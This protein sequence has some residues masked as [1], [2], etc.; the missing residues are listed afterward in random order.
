MKSFKRF[1]GEDIA[2]LRSGKYALLSP[3]GSIMG[4]FDTRHEAVLRQQELDR[5]NHEKNLVKSEKHQMN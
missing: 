1:L 2:K 5:I 4:I 3:E